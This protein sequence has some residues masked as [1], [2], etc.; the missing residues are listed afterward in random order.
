MAQRLITLYFFLMILSSCGVTVNKIDSVFYPETIQKLY[1]KQ[2]DGKKKKKLKQEELVELLVDGD[3][4]KIYAKVVLWNKNGIF[5]KPFKIINDSIPYSEE[6]IEYYHT[7][8]FV[9]F[10]TIEYYNFSKIDQIN[11]RKGVKSK[12]NWNALL[13]TTFAELALG[14]IVVTVLRPKEAWPVA[15]IFTASSLVI[16]VLSYIRLKK[17]EILKEYPMT[18]YEFV[19]TH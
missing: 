9:S 19:V 1:V 12:G 6:G 16:T 11:F 5:V 17:L 8:S 18:E 3:T 13:V 7:Y 14:G 15:Y 4:N 2:K 10:D